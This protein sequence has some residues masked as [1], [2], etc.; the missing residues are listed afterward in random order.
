MDLKKKPQ[1]HPRD[2]DFADIIKVP[3]RSREGDYQDLPVGLGNPTSPSLR[4]ERVRQREGLDRGRRREDGG[5]RGNPENDMNSQGAPG[6]VSPRASSWE[7]VS[8]S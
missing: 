3:N 8:A 6:G 5:P 7:L 1:L 2:R 4:P